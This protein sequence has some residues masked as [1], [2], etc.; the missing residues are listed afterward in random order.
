MSFAA[1]REKNSRSTQ[2]FIS[3]VDNARYDR[4]GF[5]PFGEVTMGMDVVDRFYSGYGDGAPRGE[6]PSQSQIAAEGNA[7]LVRSF[8]KLDFVKTATIEK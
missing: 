2:F 8:P 3:L 7:Y 5:V 4:R 1:T 6:G